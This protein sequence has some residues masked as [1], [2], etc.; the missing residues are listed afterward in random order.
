MVLFSP[1]LSSS[2]GHELTGAAVTRVE[3]VVRRPVV[4]TQA[5]RVALVDVVVALAGRRRRRRRHLAQDVGD[6]GSRFPIEILSWRQNV[7]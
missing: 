4:G 5:E 2:D 7:A 1:A 3:V 6:T